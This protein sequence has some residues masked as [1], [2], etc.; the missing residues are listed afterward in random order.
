MASPVVDFEGEKA[1][2]NRSGAWCEWLLPVHY[3]QNLRR[4]TDN[5]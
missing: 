2:P 3:F 4:N 1:G 5:S